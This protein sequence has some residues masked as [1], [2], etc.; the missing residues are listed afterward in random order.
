M[1]ISLYSTFM[2]ILGT[3]LLFSGCTEAVLTSTTPTNDNRL[4]SSTSI[5]NSSNLTATPGCSQ[6]LTASIS[7]TLSS[8]AVST[9]TELQNLIPPT[10]PPLPTLDTEGA[11]ILLDELLLNNAG[12]YLPCFWGITPGKTTWLEAKRFLETFASLTGIRVINGEIRYG[13]FHIPFPNDMGTIAHTYYIE[14]NTVVMITAYNGDLAPDFYL[15]VLFNTYGQ[16]D[17]IFIRTFREEEQNSQPFLLDLYYTDQGILM[18]Y[19]GG[20]IEDLGEHLRI[21]LAEMRSPFIYLW[22]PDLR[23]TFNEAQELFLDTESLPEPIPLQDATGMDISTFY[24][25]YTD[26]GTVC[27]ET[28]KE[29]WP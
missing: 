25:N 23:M 12:C 29:I 16:P 15:P 14:N 22:S 2:I 26:S 1:K 18:E 20:N 28:P 21:C 11:Q 10:L 7:P 6:T 13:S 4:H 24:E 3:S 19:S 9:P 17:S 27:I 5:I 8:G